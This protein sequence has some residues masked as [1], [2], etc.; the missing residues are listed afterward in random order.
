M[1][2]QDFTK[3]SDS[4]A[5]TPVSFTTS[6]ARAQHRHRH[7]MA[8]FVLFG[9]MLF[10]AA[11]AEAQFGLAEQGAVLDAQNE[12]QG[13]RSGRGNNPASQPEA[14]TNETQESAEDSDTDQPGKKAAAVQQIDDWNDEHS[15]FRQSA[16]SI[17]WIKLLPVLILFFAWVRSCDWINR[18]SQ[19]YELGH[20]TWNPI[21]V[22][23]FLGAFLVLILV[24]VYPIGLAL[25][26]L[27]WV[28]PFVLYVLHHNKSV[29]QHQTVFTSSWWRYQLAQLGALVGL[30]IE[31]E[32]KADYERGP[33]VDL[34]A[35]GGDER[36]NQANLLTARQSPGYVHVKEL[37]AEMSGRGSNRVLMDYTA[38]Q[39]SIRHMI[40][41]VWHSGEPRDRESG[42]VMLAVMKQL[43]NLKVAERKRKQEGV[44]L[45]E[46]QKKKYTC[47]I[48]SQ[49]VKTGERVVVSLRGGTAQT[50][51]ETLS[52]LG[53][54]EKL[55][56]QWQEIMSA[57]KGVIVYSAM[58][59]GGLTTLTDIGLI[60]TDRL[61][62]DFVAVEDQDDPQTEIENIPAHFYDGPKGESP[63]S[64]IPTLSRKY[65][66]VWVV[67]DFVDAESAKLLMEEV[68][69]D[70]LVVTTVH[71]KEAAEACLRLLQ[72]KVPHKEFSRN[73]IGVLN[74]RL[75]RTLCPDC[76]VGY[77]ATPALLKKLGIPSGKV[78]TFYRQPKAEEIEKPCKTCNGL[79]FKGRTGLFELLPVDDQ[80]RS[81]LLKEPKPDV[82]RKSARAAG[83]RTL[84]EEGVLLVAKGLTSLPELQRVLKG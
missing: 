1:K 7:L 56:E 24:P 82:L 48:T 53:M 14:S 63:A 31:T 76:K 61:L 40:D 62:R 47:V 50:S 68:D 67:R 37:V 45:A 57:E 26:S 52:D 84:Q 81:K 66:N 60:E 49:G 74:T 65:P 42:D 28:V 44:Y 3:R 39:V 9:L 11:P 21:M 59:E 69:M 79:G 35:Q 43:A 10:G 27:A 20:E 17:S 16:P 8:A 41:G 5:A 70:R 72:K 36:T 78:S 15:I 33:A 51:F 32:K 77:E 22:F 55:C 13:G 80:F 38:E 73:V 58:P 23:P 4:M 64:L 29:E 18:D 6:R 19:M 54:R 71:A 25:M 34:H 46:Y 12:M 30:K 75:I 83:M 2:Q